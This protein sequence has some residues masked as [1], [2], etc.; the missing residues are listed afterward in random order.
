MICEKEFIVATEMAHKESINLH[1]VAEALV[2]GV[3]KPIG[4]KPS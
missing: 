3:T 4:E 1:M 2:R